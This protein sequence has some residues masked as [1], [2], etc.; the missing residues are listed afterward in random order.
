MSHSRESESKENTTI[1]ES[2]VQTNEKKDSKKETKIEFNK[3]TPIN[4]FELGS[5]EEGLDF[6][7]SQDDIK[8]IAVTGPY[9]AGKTSLIN[10]YKEL[11]PDKAFINISLA[12]FQSDK[13]E[14]GKIIETATS[15]E[16]ES[17]KVEKEHSLE[18]NILE[19]KILNQ[20]LHQIDPKKIPKTNFK[21][22]EKIPKKKI[23]WNT[24]L[25]LILGLSSAFIIFYNSWIAFIPNF[26][27]SIIVSIANFTTIPD[28]LL[29]IGLVSILIIAKFL[30][31]LFVI[32]NNRN[33]F[34]KLNLQGNQIEILEE[35]DDS[36][37]DKYLNEVIYIFENSNADAIIFEDIDRYNANQI[38]GKL[39][40]IN[41]LVNNKK[42]KSV[43]K[44]ENSKSNFSKIKLFQEW[45]KI[46]ILRKNELNTIAKPVRFIFSL[47]DDVF[48]SKDRTKFFDFILPV[49]PVL[50]GSNSYEQFLKE[51]ESE[52]ER[53]SIDLKFLQGVSIYVDDMR[54]LK[55]IYNEFHIYQSNLNKIELDLN[56]LLALVTYKNIFPRDFSELQLN[57]GFVYNLF[58]QKLKFL[59]EV[60]T[61]TEE[62][63]EYKQ[64]LLTRISNEAAKNIEE[65]DAIYFNPPFQIYD[66]GSRLVTDFDS[67]VELIK[68]L[69]ENPTSVRAIYNRVQF[70]TVDVERIF[71][72][73]EDNP[74]Y[75]ERKKII[76]YKASSEYDK[77]NSEIQQLRKQRNSL[78]NKKLQQIINP[79]NIDSI[80]RT[81]YT[82]E[83]GTLSEFKEIKSS[84][85]FLLIKYL[86]RNGYIDESYP[87]Y[88]TYFYGHSGRNISVEDKNFLRSIYD[89]VAKDYSYTLKNPQ[90]IMSRL[91]ISYF[92]NREILNF[93]LFNH[94]LSNPDTNYKYLEAFITHLNESKNFDFVESFMDLNLHKSN[95]IKSLNTHWP[96]FF[97]EM[98]SL[99]NY[100]ESIKRNIAFDILVYS[101]ES[102]F[103]KINKLRHLTTYISND[104][105]F[106]NVGESNIEQFVKKLE[107]LNVSFKDIDFE[108]A[109][110]ILLREV[111]QKKLFELNY[112]LIFK[113]LQEV[114]LIEN[115]TSLQ[116]MNYSMIISK[117]DESLYDYVL[118]NI[119]KYLET[120]LDNCGGKITDEPKAILELI[121]N[122]DIEH[123]TKIQYLNVL[124]NSIENIRDVEDV[125]L[126]QTL[127]NNR[128]VAFDVSNVYSYFFYSGKGFDTCLIDFINNFESKISLDHDFIE[129]N[130]EGDDAA[131]SLYEAVICTNSL[132][133][134]KYESLLSPINWYYDTFH[135]ENID[136]DKIAIL[137]RLKVIRMTIDNL[138][139]IRNEHFDLLEQFITENIE[140]YLHLLQPV[141]FELHEALIL[142]KSSIETS[143]KLRILSF[144]D[145]VISLR[146]ESFEDEVR[147]YIIENH[148]DLE[149][150]QFLLDN[151]NDDKSSI[152]KK[153]RE[154]ISEQFNYILR[155]NLSIPFIILKEIFLDKQLSDQ[156]NKQLL[157]MN[158]KNFNAN[159]AR[160]LFTFLNLEDYLSLFEFGR[161]KITKT[162]EDKQLLEV[163]KEKNWI[164]K[165]KIEKNEPSYYRVFSRK[166]K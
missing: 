112:S 117:K 54:I 87:D 127:L 159:E 126:W 17:K 161:P 2:D 18:D 57:S 141:N 129:S 38:F 88:M 133:N 70:Q 123:E 109:N 1:N 97:K 63:I 39:R 27:N 84:P 105:G 11:N 140:E 116:H 119:Q 146:Y 50:D 155:E 166:I 35:S 130:F 115:E 15:E 79:T 135:F 6:V 72:N 61:K 98:D 47:R 73:L 150:L 41:T 154:L 8:N 10:T 149:D 83:I 76:Q 108:N 158:L 71:A 95:F 74:E 134:K 14:K 12:H 77:L 131:L 132:D 157:A 60:I 91:D 55:N 94:L 103:E 45:I 46:K 69:R 124:E 16:S 43:K 32:Q 106:L 139:F 81:N 92:Q 107:L 49:V 99:S 163:L 59:E 21:I 51:F 101:D 65:L 151:Y 102:D 19:A 66:V 78:K 90:L 156:Q 114:Y 148:F 136:S 5:Y 25:I 24:I 56:K 26:S 68:A 125:E 13:T 89:E 52:V 44:K 138:E 29:M 30:Y 82:N 128:L 118:D 104:K 120:I 67:R 75:V 121:N 42:L 142:L 7:F 113:F 36:Y 122:V 80:F 85:Y 33:I 53:R 153:I 22:K 160:E 100:V 23:F 37:F 110:R 96:Y 4:D 145:S 9:G 164:S 162:T 86:I 34:K 62:E 58:K 28:F 3:L 93:D 152:Q 31:E 143:H 40:E 144:N 147:E 64:E 137:L 111:Y 48:V 165:Y 20:L